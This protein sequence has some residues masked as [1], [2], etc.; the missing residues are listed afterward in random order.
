MLTNEVE[1]G[2]LKCHRYWPDAEANEDAAEITQAPS[3]THGDITVELKSKETFEHYIVRTFRL[4]NL[5]TFREVKQYQYIVW[6]DHGVPLTTGEVLSFRAAIRD[7]ETQ[8]KPWVV[9]CSAGVGRT[10]TFMAIDTMLNKAAARA[11]DMSIDDLVKTFRMQ[12]NYMVQTD[13]QYVFVHNAVHDAFEK[14]L[15]S[16]RQLSLQSSQLNEEARQKREEELEELKK[17]IAE[18]KAQQQAEYEE[19]LH[20][21]SHG[22]SSVDNANIVAKITGGVST[23]I[24][25][26]Q[27][28]H[29]KWM[30][31]Y[32]KYEAKRKEVTEAWEEAEKGEYGVDVGMSESETFA[33]G[34]RMQGIIPNPGN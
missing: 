1:K 7:Y 27:S 13:L 30:E 3:V 14:L 11:E 31:N 21:I 29:G 28:T 10:G 34:L 26:L 5:G 20:E 17:E 18:R 2:K 16:E 9:H 12:R 19:L 15:Q 33:E 8:D 6:P 32:Q 22:S 23:K 24:K 4:S 25:S